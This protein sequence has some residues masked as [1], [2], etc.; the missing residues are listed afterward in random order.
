[1]ALTTPP[2]VESVVID[3]VT[4][5]WVDSDRP[6]LTAVLR[7]GFGYAHEPFNEAGWQHLIEHLCLHGRDQGILDIN[8]LVDP[9]VTEFI[10]HGRPAEVVEHF[11]QVIAWL[12]RPDFGDLDVERR[13]L[14]AESGGMGGGPVARAALTR[15]GPVGTGLRAFD[16]PGLATATPEG[17][18]ARIADVFT[19]ANAVMFFD[20]PVPDGLRLGLPSGVRTAT[21]TFTPVE[22]F[23]AQYVDPVLV[24]SGE[25]STRPGGMLALEY[26]ER[27]LTQLLR[28]DT[29]AT[30]EVHSDPADLL[31][32]RLVLTLGADLADGTATNIVQATI[33]WLD[34]QLTAPVDQAAVD[35]LREKRR[36]AILEETNTIWLAGAAARDH[37]DGITPETREEMIARLDSV[38]AADVRDRLQEFRATLLIGAP[39]TAGRAD[40]IDLLEAGMVEVEPPGTR[41][42]THANAPLDTTR[43]GLAAG[44]VVTDLGHQIR[45]WPVESLHAVLI[46]RGVHGGREQEQWRFIDRAG[47]GF[48]F[49]VGAYPAE[50]VRDFLTRQLP[51]SAFVPTEDPIDDFEPVGWFGRLI[52]GWSQWAGRLTGSVFWTLMILLAAAALALGAWMSDGLGIARGVGW[53]LQVGTG[54]FIVASRALRASYRNG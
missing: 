38:T 7:F 48:S 23:P 12:N 54:V 24:L 31:P 19:T 50:E 15:W 9:Y 5:F 4:C 6:S 35:V 52:G 27:G 30:Y 8:G 16:E 10:A 53:T 40:T 42:W 22:T 13:V 37:L 21:P 29:G 26:L 45:V 34:A 25:V 1:M 17:L 11:H 44:A 43:L 36:R 32:D 51:A 20:G 41:W 3:G 47:Y 39:E 33:A 18:Q 14:R 49:S 46:H 2:I 28:H